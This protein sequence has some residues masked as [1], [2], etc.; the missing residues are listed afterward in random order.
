MDKLLM[1]RQKMMH[2]WTGFTRCFKSGLDHIYVPWTQ[3]LWLFVVLG[4]C[5]NSPFTCR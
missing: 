4:I 2:L 3:T 5:V 1:D